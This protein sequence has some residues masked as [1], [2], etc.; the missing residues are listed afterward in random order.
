MV[1]GSFRVAALDESTWPAYRALIEL[2]N[3]VFGG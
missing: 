3:G 2:N 1:T